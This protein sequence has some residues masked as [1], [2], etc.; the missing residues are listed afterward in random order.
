MRE[1][2]LPRPVT[3]CAPVMRPQSLPSALLLHCHLQNAQLRR[4]AVPCSWHLGIA[5]AES[6]GLSRLERLL[7]EVLHRCDIGTFGIGCL[8]RHLLCQEW[9]AVLI[10]ENRRNDGL[11]DR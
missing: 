9:V 4:L 7:S 5:H 10:T 6:G 1:I 3:D 2:L 8:H 11:C